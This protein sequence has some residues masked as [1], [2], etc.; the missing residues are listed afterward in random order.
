MA[1]PEQVVAQ[2]CQ[3][4]VSRDNASQDSADNPPHETQNAGEQGGAETQPH[5]D[6]AEY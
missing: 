4:D 5:P 3:I 2:R 6:N 1:S